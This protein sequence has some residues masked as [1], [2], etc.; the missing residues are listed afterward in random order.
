MRTLAVKMYLGVFVFAVAGCASTAGYE[1]VLRSWVGDSQDNLVSTWGNPDSQY[2]LSSGGRV[3]QYS[4][5]ASIMIPGQTAYQPVTTYQS[6]TATLTSINGVTA[7]GAYNGTSTTYVPHT[8]DPVII[9]K[10][11]TT[12]FTVDSSGLITNWA[13]QGSACL[14]VAPKQPKEECTDARVRMGECKWT[15]GRPTL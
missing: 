12:R 8:S 15:D 6:G 7:N 9:A 11:C 5:S 4:R 10:N 14:A 3:L 13:W 2:P 1:A